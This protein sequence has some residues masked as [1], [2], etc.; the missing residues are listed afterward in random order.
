MD[1]LD[2]DKRAMLQ[3]IA[4]IMPVRDMARSIE[5]YQRLGFV[6]ELYDDG[7]DSYAFL[8]RDE[9]SLHLSRMDGPEWTL[10]PTGVYLYVS[11]VDVFYDVVMAAGVAC[12][13]APE[14]KA[15]RMREFAVNDP[16]GALLRFGERMPP[17]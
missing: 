11:D 17:R 2:G 3:S 5:F 8:F 13:H 10:N 1:V 16:D 6:C 15:W 4:A 9:Q 14:D 7:L 12:L